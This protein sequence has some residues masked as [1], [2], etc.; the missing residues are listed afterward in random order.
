MELK[1]VRTTFTENSTIG[2]LSIDGEFECYTLED[3]VRDKKIYGET[4]IPYGRYEV[5]VT[6]SPRF[7]KRL[8]RLLNVPNFEGVLI[9]SGNDKNATNGCIL[10]GKTKQEDWVGQS[11]DALKA[12]LPKIE[13]ALE[14]KEKVFIEIGKE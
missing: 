2:T 3:K 11:R 6:L 1:L 14:R 10:V 12:L 4:A 13:A 5:I 9:H 8:P 7:Q